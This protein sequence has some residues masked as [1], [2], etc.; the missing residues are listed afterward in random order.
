MGRIGCTTLIKSLV[1][2][3]EGRERRQKLFRDS[4][5]SDS[6]LAQRAFETRRAETSRVCLNRQ[7]MGLA[8]ANSKNSKVN[9]KEQFKP[10]DE[11]IYIS[12]GPR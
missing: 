1:P 3:D 4:T 5:D 9:H 12:S 11:Y 10:F 7:A 8:V 6:F 2:L